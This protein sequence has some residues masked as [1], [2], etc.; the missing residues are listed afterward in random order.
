MVK[1]AWESVGKR[2]RGRMLQKHFTVAGA[3]RYGYV[4]RSFEYNQRKQ[5][6]KGHRNPLVWSGKSKALAKMA[7]IRT[8]R[9]GAKVI[10]R[11]PTLNRTP[12]GRRMNMNRELTRVT[13]AEAELLAELLVDRIDG[14][15]KRL[16]GEG[17]KK[18]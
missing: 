5:R 12:R 16:K 15:I 9:K 18:G 6:E 7:T 13:T 14:Q 17:R 4:R 1:A 10:M 11:V 2:W 8:T 3:S